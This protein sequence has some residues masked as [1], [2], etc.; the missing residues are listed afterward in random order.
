MNEAWPDRTDCHG[1]HESRGPAARPHGV[2]TPVTAVR[3]R[4]IISAIMR[5][6][7]KTRGHYYRGPNH[8]GASSD[9]AVEFGSVAAATQCA[10]TEHLPDAEIALRSDYL[11]HEIGM[12]VLREWCELDE[13][14]R[15]KAEQRV[16]QREG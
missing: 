11:D 9:E 4:L 5:V 10:L 8:A 2:N 14:Q 16:E 12:P 3:A 13:N 1:G 7:L 15:L 6:Y